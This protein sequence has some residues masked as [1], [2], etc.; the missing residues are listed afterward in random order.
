[1]VNAVSA[2]HSNYRLTK[3]S[4]EDKCVP[5]LELGNEVE[6]R[7]TLGSEGGTPMNGGNSPLPAIKESGDAR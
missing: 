7:V 6:E 5:K 3:Q 4:F 1:M 2:T